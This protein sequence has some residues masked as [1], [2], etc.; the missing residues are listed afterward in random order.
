MHAKAEPAKPE[1][2]K[3]APAGTPSAPTVPPATLVFSIQPWGEVFVNGKQSG[4][5]PPMK[6][7][8]L[9]PGKYR[10]EVRNS[11]FAAHV[12]SVE[13]KSRDELTI[14]HRFQ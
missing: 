10:I 2:P 1:A 11:T 5:S 14:R 6:S 4:V 7:L 12:E 9:A 13:V 3:G 8:K